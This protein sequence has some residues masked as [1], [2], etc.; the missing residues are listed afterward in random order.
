M[1]DALRRLEAGGS[2]LHGPLALGAFCGHTWMGC[3]SAKDLSTAISK[4]WKIMAVDEH[5]SHSVGGLWC[6]VDKL[7]RRCQGGSQVANLAC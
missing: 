1:A 4:P 7:H 2:S 5:L 6:D 3:W